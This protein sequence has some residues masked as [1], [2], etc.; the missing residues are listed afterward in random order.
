MTDISVS[1]R[2]LSAA[3]DRIDQLL[4]G[5][6]GRPGT[7]AAEP[8]AALRDQ[9]AELQAQNTRLAAELAALRTDQGGPLEATLAEARNRL[10]GASEQAARLAAAN[11]DLAAANRALIEAAR[12]D[13]GAEQASIE[14]LEAEIEALRA[15]RAAEIAQ[16]GDIM[17][18]LERL[19]APHDARPTQPRDVEDAVLPEVAGDSAGVPEDEAVDDDGARGDAAEDRRPYAAQD[20]SNADGMRED[21]DR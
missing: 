1:E 10:G 9:L 12:G 20:S 8:D 2:R 17:L 11:D 7:F 4:E 16:M 3:L 5:G 15:A 21:G 6:A 14:A 19:L 18:E 13:G